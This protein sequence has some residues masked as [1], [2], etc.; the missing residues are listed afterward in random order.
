MVSNSR[1][2]HHRHQ[3]KQFI[4]H[5]AEV[6]RREGGGGD[7]DQDYQSQR[8]SRPNNIGSDGNN[9]NI[10]SYHYRRERQRL[11]RRQ[12]DSTTTDEDIVTHTTFH[13]SQIHTSGDPQNRHRSASRERGGGRIKP[14]SRSS[15]SSRQPASSN[16]SRGQ[17]QVFL[18]VPAQHPAQNPPE[19]GRT[20][21]RPGIAR[22]DTS[23]FG[24]R[25]SSSSAS[26]QN[27]FYNPIHHHQQQQQQQTRG[28]RDKTNWWTTRRRNDSYNTDT[29][30]TEST[31]GRRD[32]LDSST[33]TESTLTVNGKLMPSSVSPQHMNSLVIEDALV[34]SP[35]KWYQS[36]GKHHHDRQ[37]NSKHHHHEQTQ[38]VHFGE[39]PSRAR[40]KSPRGANSARISRSRSPQ[41]QRK[42]RPTAESLFYQAQSADQ[43][44]VVPSGNTVDRIDHGSYKTNAQHQK[45]SLLP[46]KRT[47]LYL[48][49][50]RA[51]PEKNDVNPSER[52]G[53]QSSIEE[54]KDFS[55]DGHEE[56]SILKTRLDIRSGTGSTRKTNIPLIKINSQAMPKAA[57][58]ASKTSAHNKHPEASLTGTEV[59]LYTESVKQRD[60]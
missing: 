47:P 49:P 6:H 2:R 31:I 32:K 46:L 7:F 24:Q 54:G 45:T 38:S 17:G 30:T 51:A 29:S 14:R 58:E 28:R 50:K 19:R 25:S 16:R 42:P 56:N 22:E 8:N 53:Q 12:E 21:R 10:A 59:P 57:S 36:K 1:S 43:A 55:S 3:Q 41:N 11:A 33:R 5:V 4:T 52:S 39:R 35:A 18:T 60:R 26:P 15:S 9:D 37:S 27:K 48:S 20:A 40:S 13:R 23:N 34:S 44:S